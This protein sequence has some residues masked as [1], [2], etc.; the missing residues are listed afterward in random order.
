[1]LVIPLFFFL[2]LGSR[3]VSGI[4]FVAVV[5]MIA[6]LVSAVD[7]RNILVFQKTRGGY[8]WLRE[9]HPSFLR[10]LPPWPYGS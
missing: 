5:V 6:S 7:C 10:H 2:P 4:F 9:A 1:M 3:L 8:F